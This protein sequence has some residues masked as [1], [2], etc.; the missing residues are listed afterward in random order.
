[1]QTLTKLSNIGP[2]NGA[3]KTQH[4]TTK[5]TKEIKSINKKRPVSKANRAV[6]A[7]NPNS[8]DLTQSSETRKTQNN[9][10]KTLKIMSPKPK[11]ICTI[12]IVIHLLRQEVAEEEVR[13]IKTKTRFKC[14]QT[15]TLQQ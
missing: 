11:W 6:L 12:S 9:K 15:Q 4:S 1:M 5:K 8:P 10:K 7:P 13:N 2:V 3:K 14:S